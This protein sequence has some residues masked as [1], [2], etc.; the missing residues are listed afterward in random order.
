MKLVV[1]EGAGK[2]DSIKKFLGSGYEVFPTKGHVVDLP[3]KTL[4]VSIEKNFEPSY[5]TMPDK[6]DIEKTLKLKAKTADE[7]LLA[8]DPDREG[9]AISWH[10]ARILGIDETAPVRIVFNEISK[11]AIEEALKVP[12][13]INLDLVDAY[14]ARRVLDRLVGYKLSPYLNK[15][16]S[17]AKLSAGRVQS[18]TLKIVVDR[19]EEIRNFKPE[20]YWNIALILSKK[21]DKNK[22]NHFKAALAMKDGKKIKIENKEQSDEVLAAVEKAKIIIQKIKESVTSSKAA[23]PYITS[24]MQQDALNKLGMSLARSGKAAQELY[25]GVSFKGEKLPLVTYIRTDSTRISDA[26]RTMAYDHIK[27]VYGQEFIPE[28][29]NFFKT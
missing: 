13:A 15:K 22:K 20:E 27:A 10:I 8:T 9:E 25:E 21:N 2:K 19:E 24:T 29:P 6:K 17:G 7:I 1:I 5:T 26:A 3:K 11:K 18:A 12:R 4:A 28:K 16:I 14:Q 23:A